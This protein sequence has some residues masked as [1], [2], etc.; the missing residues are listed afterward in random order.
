VP[1]A[2]STA[3]CLSH[4]QSQNFSVALF[5]LKIFY[6][7]CHYLTEKYPRPPPSVSSPIPSLPLL[8]LLLLYYMA[9]CACVLFPS[10]DNLPI[11]FP[12]RM[13]TLP[14]HAFP[15]AFSS[16]PY[17]SLITHSVFSLPP[18]SSFLLLLLDLP[19]F[20]S[21]LPVS[22][23]F[24]FLHTP[25]WIFCHRHF[26]LP[27]YRHYVLYHLLFPSLLSRFFFLFFF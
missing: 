12:M 22:F 3:N 20:L 21:P 25:S 2:I 23:L 7:I 13:Y 18:F 1:P 15:L 9:F 11:R 14:L 10:P 27:L 6:V 4:G 17:V 26:P 19:R 16:F 8:S 5:D 24:L